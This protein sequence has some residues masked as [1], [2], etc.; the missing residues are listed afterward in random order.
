MNRHFLNGY[1]ALVALACGG[2]LSHVAV[3]QQITGYGVDSTNTL[4]SFTVTA[5]LSNVANVM[6][7]GAVGAVGFLPEGID[8]RPGTDDLYAIDVGPNT[9]TVYTLDITTGASTIVGSFTSSGAGY[10][11]TTNQTF[12]FD[13]NPKTLQAGD[14]SM[15]I[16]LVGTSGTNLRLNSNTGQIAVI[17]PNVQFGNGNSPFID[18]A[19]YIN[20]IPAS[21]GAT[22]LFDMDS[23]NDE[24]LSQDPA[25]GVV[26]TIGSFGF[27]ID[28][29]RNIHFDV[30]TTSGDA[31]PGIGGDFGFAVMRR[32]ATSANAYLVYDVNLASGATTV[33]RLV[34][35]VGSPRD[36]DGGFAALPVPEPSG[37]VV[38]LVAC[39]ALWRRRRRRQ[40]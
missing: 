6:N 4:F 39:A 7:R 18:A 25:T 22:A 26:A 23:R 17:D 37:A 13:F 34:G 33:G 3:G 8:F 19:A 35:P 30:V 27:G 31:D 2:A 14:G 1:C 28:A 5:G 40:A 29:N 10:D 21:S 9:T 32:T 24:L 15:R 36:F 12:G 20:N 16:R 38:A 11:L